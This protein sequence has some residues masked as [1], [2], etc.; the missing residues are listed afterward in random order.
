MIDPSNTLVEIIMLDMGIVPVT[1][2]RHHG[3]T[4]PLGS[5]KEMLAGLSP[6]DRRRITRKF[7]KLW[8]K[9]YNSPPDLKDRKGMFKNRKPPGHEIQ[10]RIWAIRSM[11]STDSENF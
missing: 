10:R 2:Y 1:P 7:R 4:D 3:D 6:D 8:R 5:V 11:I 9:A